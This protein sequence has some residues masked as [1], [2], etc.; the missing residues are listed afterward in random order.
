MSIDL[1]I[2]NYNFHELLQIFKI[3]NFD[4]SEENTENIKKYCSI[5]EKNYSDDIYKLYFKASKI[6][7]CIYKLFNAS[8]ISTDNLERI[9]YFVNEIKKI[10]SF[11][12][13]DSNKIIN[14]HLKISIL[15]DPEDKKIQTFN[16]YENL[17]EVNY[18]LDNKINPVLNDKNNTNIVLDSFTNSAAPGKLNSIKRI[19]HFQNLNLNSCFR[20]NYYTC[21]S[22]DFQYL[23]PCELKNVISLRL[24]SIEI[25]NAWYLFSNKQKNNIFKI[26]IEAD[27]IIT[28]YNI[29]IYN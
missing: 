6:I 1:D 14:K 11:E 3:N 25:P 7:D 27:G 19:T 21:S 22:T 17:N 20:H 2:N 9:N 18:N 26:I 23:L 13:F 29:V 8:I 16:K 5:I 4:Y 28:N 12:N 10:N 24:A 15:N